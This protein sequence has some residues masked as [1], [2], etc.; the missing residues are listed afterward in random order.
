MYVG[1]VAADDAQGAGRTG[2]EQAQALLDA[3]LDV[4]GP[5]LD[6]QVL[7][8]TVWPNPQLKIEFFSVQITSHRPRDFSIFSC[9][10]GRIVH[11]RHGKTPCSAT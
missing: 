7:P 8:C 10:L 6:D 4:L 11:V 1:L 3:A 2:Q 9:I 5:W